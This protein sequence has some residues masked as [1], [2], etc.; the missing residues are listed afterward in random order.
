VALIDDYKSYE[1][2][3]PNIRI[4]RIIELKSA[5]FM[6]DHDLLPDEVIRTHPFYRDF[7]QP[8]GYGWVAGSV[9]QVPTGETLVFGVERHYSRGPVERHFIEALDTVR[10]HLAR[11]ALLS[12]RLRLERARAMADALGMVGIPSAVLQTSGRMI[13]ANV[14]FEAMVPAVFRDHH[15]GL[16][17]NDASA[18][19]LLK[20]ALGARRLAP[21]SFPIA[22]SA[23]RPP[24]IVHLLPVRGQAA[25]IF[26]ATTSVMAVTPVVPSMVPTAEVL[27]GLFDLTPT[28][29]RVARQ[30]GQGKSAKEA[31]RVMG[32]GY[33]T[34]RG[35]ISAI[36]GK[37]GLHRQTELATLLA[38]V[39]IRPP[40]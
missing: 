8:R 5:G 37:T 11:A 2:L 34:V 27:Q 7:M 22:A 9:V 36:L 17:I 24:M 35:H 32:V 21:R 6:N 13:A 29:A 40:A 33:E 19:A 15:S 28:E 20:S 23:E 30:I 3:T 25:D 10:P 14:E 38:G 18:D 16:A 4:P 12:A 39:P 1:Q 31:A 26:P